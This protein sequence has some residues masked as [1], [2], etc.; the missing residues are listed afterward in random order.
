MASSSS[1]AENGHRFRC[2]LYGKDLIL[3]DGLN[4]QTFEM[5]AAELGLKSLVILAG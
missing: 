4:C 1:F 3:G 2:F 5:L